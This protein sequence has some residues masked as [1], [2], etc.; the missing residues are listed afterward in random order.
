[1]RA[2]IEEWVRLGDTV[3]SCLLL[4]NTAKDAGDFVEVGGEPVVEKVIESLGLKRLKF[5]SEKFETKFSYSINDFFR[6]N[7]C[8][9]SFFDSEMPFFNNKIIK[10]DFKIETL[11]EIELPVIDSCKERITSTAERQ[12]KRNNA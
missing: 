8:G 4:D 6:T 11:K 10:C 9:V 1:M 5:L 7:N 3:T 12:A 2:R